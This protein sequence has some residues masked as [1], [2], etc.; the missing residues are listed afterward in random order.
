MARV[1]N[2]LAL[3]ALM[4]M[5]LIMQ[6]AAAA[7]VQHQQAMSMEMPAEHCPDEGS[8][9]GTKGKVAVCAMICSAAL[10]ASELPQA[11][12]MLIVC[13]PAAPDVAQRLSDHDP[14][15]ATPPPRRS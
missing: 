2:L 1:M 3:F 5:P 13:K 15:I 6:P 7:P 8:I 11:Q 9:P 12:R 4:L 14:E 10:P